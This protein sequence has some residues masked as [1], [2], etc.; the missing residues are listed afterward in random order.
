LVELLEGAKIAK[1]EQMFPEPEGVSTFIPEAPQRDQHADVLPEMEVVKRTEEDIAQLFGELYSDD[2]ST[3]A[4]AAALLAEQEP[5]KLAEA[6]LKAITSDM[7]LKPRRLVASVIKRAGKPA[8]EMLLRKVSLDMPVLSLAKVVMVL[9]IFFDSPSLIP[10]LRQIVLL[11][12]SE[13][14]P[15]AVE[16]LKQIPGE[17]IDMLLL[18]LFQIGQGKTKLDILGIFADRKILRSVP[19]LLELIEPKKFWEKEPRVLLQTHACRTLGVLQTPE[20]ID[21]LITVASPAK[22]W[23]VLKSRP[24][25]VR[26][27][28]TKALRLFPY[29]PKIAGVLNKLQNDRSPLVRR[30]ASE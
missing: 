4:K 23:S 13:V 30:A 15:L 14:L 3:R 20:A 6:G 9:D 5:T 29:Q 12:P 11:G 25:S 28:A 7:P 19:S 26:V 1:V 2:V 24:V 21:T 8:V 17:E 10:L 27:A 16:V 22:P 18:E